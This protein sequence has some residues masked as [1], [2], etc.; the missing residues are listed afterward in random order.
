MDLVISE[1]RIRREPMDNYNVQ[2]IAFREASS[3]G[4]MRTDNYYNKL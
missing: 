4:A 1:L 3:H 2:E